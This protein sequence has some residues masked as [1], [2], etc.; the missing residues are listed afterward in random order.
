MEYGMRLPMVGVD[1]KHRVPG[2]PGVPGLENITKPKHGMQVSFTLNQTTK[3]S[4][5][6]N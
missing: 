1:K 6:P 4:T 5:S 2:L 3:F